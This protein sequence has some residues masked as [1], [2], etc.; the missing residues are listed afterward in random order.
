[1]KLTGAAVL[2]ASAAGCRTA[3]A[4]QAKGSSASE[5]AVGAGSAAHESAGTA[6]AAAKKVY[7]ESEFAP[8]KRVVLTQ[9]EVSMGSDG[10][11]LPEED[12][13]AWEKERAE[14]EAVLKKYDVE[15]QRPR[16]LTDEEKKLGSVENGLTAGQGVTNFF[17][18][19]PFFTIGEHII[20]GGFNSPYRRLEVLPARSILEKEAQDS[21][22]YYVALPQPDISSGLEDTKGPFLEG[23]DV[24][25]YGKTVFVGNSGAASNETGITWLRNYLGHFGYEV[26]EV[27]LEE[28][29]LHLDCALSLVREGLMIVCEQALPNGIPEQLKDWDK[30]TVT[31]DQTQE[32]ATNGLPINESVYVTD[33]AFKDVVGAELEKRSI[34][35]EYV[36]FQISRQ[37]GGAFRCSTQPLLRVSA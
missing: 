29:I 16:L 9:S 24:L 8:L 10:E 32:L 11:T 21:G 12:Q 13:A 26:V 27:K 36:D 28:N 6:D 17:V 4:K 14:L 20:E 3:H 7:V 1:M 22:C 18:R 37:F 34:T 25:V 35:V 19:D 33:P 5:E 30:I 15:V 23:G 2:T 31:Y